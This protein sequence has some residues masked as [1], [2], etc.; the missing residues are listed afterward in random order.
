MPFYDEIIAKYLGDS[1]D[2]TLYQVCIYFIKVLTIFLTDTQH[3]MIG[4]MRSMLQEQVMDAFLRNENIATRLPQLE[5]EV[6]EGSTTP[7]MA[8][9][10]LVGLGASK[11]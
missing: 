2:E 8:V 4:W 5:R 6:S 10:E 11:L 9:R 7:V 3:Q 1:D